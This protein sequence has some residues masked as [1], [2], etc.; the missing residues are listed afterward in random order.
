MWH[1]GLIANLLPGLREVRAPLAAGFL[2]LALI[3]LATRKYLSAPLPEGSLIADLYRLFG[4]LGTV[5][6]LAVSAFIAY[7]IGILSVAITS[8]ALSRLARIHRR[9][10]AEK[11]DLGSIR[12]PLSS[13]GLASVHTLVEDQIADVLSN[14][15]QA[16]LRALNIHPEAKALL[17][18]LASNLEL[19]ERRRL[20]SRTIATDEHFRSIIADL[21]LVPIRLIGNKMELYSA[22]D[23]LMAEGEFRAAI[24]APCIGIGIGLAATIPTMWP[25]P[26]L[27][28][29][30]A[31]VLMLQARSR[32]IAAYDQL[33]EALR[34]SGGKDSPSAMAIKRAPLQFKRTTLRPAELAILVQRAEAAE[35]Q[36]QLPRAIEWYAIVADAGIGTAH[37]KL[38]DITRTTSSA[39][40]DGFRILEP[41]LIEGGSYSGRLAVEAL[42][43]ILHRVPEDEWADRQFAL[44]I[45]LLNILCSADHPK[46]GFQPI[47]GVYRLE[48]LDV[49]HN[50][51]LSKNIQRVYTRALAPTGFLLEHPLPSCRAKRCSQSTTR[52]RRVTNLRRRRPGYVR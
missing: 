30:L 13:K 29:L 47:A 5:V 27:A 34:A 19:A 50:Y 33:A 20:L 48:D 51:A 36:N 16:K 22:H 6:T 26:M 18:T 15:E 35:K 21:E 11:A 45:T 52:C 41:R 38:C 40:T 32:V 25:A 23:R 10:P 43:L 2:W 28:V 17:G 1:V 44:G 24:S 46:T 4:W 37:E 3:L 42:E 39:Y 14:D 8:V 31:T 9:S 7:L 49:Q 12:T